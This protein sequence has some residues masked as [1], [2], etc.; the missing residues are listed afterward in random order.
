MLAAYQS[1]RLD[2]LVLLQ[3]SPP[4]T[5]MSLTSLLLSV[6]CSC[7]VVVG[8]LRRERLA[9]FGRQLLLLKPAGKPYA[10]SLQAAGLVL[11]LERL[12]LLKQRGELYT[13]SIET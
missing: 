5:W 11:A 3:G 12:H 7:R 6:L 10:L 9:E 13:S 8:E 2:I 4:S 1:P